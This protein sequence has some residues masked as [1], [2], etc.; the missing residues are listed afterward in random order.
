V[1]EDHRSGHTDKWTDHLCH[2]FSF[3]V[4]PG[5]LANLDFFDFSPSLSVHG[6]YLARPVNTAFMICLP[7]K[8]CTYLCSSNHLS[9]SGPSLVSFW[10]SLLLFRPPLQS[11]LYTAVNGHLQIEII[12][13][14]ICAETSLLAA[15]QLKNHTI[16][17]MHGT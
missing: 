5:P 9:S 3:N 11:F 13:C 10:F 7:T 4:R 15:E 16:T 14:H 1:G 8:H 6:H 12:L 2:L 17:S